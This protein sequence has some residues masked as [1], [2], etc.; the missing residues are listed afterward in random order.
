MKPIEEDQDWLERIKMGEVAAYAFLV[1]K[2]KSMVYTIALKILRNREDAEDVAQECFL[3]A[4]QQIRQF[5][6]KSKFSTWLYTITYRTALSHLKENRIQTSAITDE[7][8]ETY[9]TTYETPQHEELQL[10]QEV[11]RI[12]DAIQNLP[13]IEAL[14]VTLFYINDSTVKEIHEITGLSVTNIKIKL[15]RARKKLERKLSFL[16]ECN[17]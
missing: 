6:G 5:Q 4:Y 13:S 9:T 2:Y 7:L 8:K 15:F 11:A 16:F 12:K 14:L 1:D 17:G 3:K 10:K